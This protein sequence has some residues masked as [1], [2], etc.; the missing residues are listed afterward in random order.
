MAEPSPLVLEG[1]VK[2]FVD[3]GAVDGV[4]LEL[5]PGELLALVGPSGCG[6]STL[7]RLVAGLISPDAGRVTLGGQVVSDAHQQLPPE[8]RNVGLVFQEHALFPHLTVEQNVSFGLRDLGRSEAKSRVRES[9]ALVD[10]TDF[11]RRYPHELSGGERQRVALARALAPRPT[12]L[13][14]DEPFAS[15]DPNL[16][17]QLRAAVV[18]ALR[19]TGTPAVFVTHDQTEALAVGDRIA[20][21]RRGQIRQ[22]GTPERVFHQPVE[23]F[24]AAFMGEASFLAVA[25]GTLATALGPIEPSASVDSGQDGGVAMVRPDDLEFW[26][27]TDGAEP[28]AGAG[29]DEIIAT[30][31]RGDRWC[32]TIRLG[33][34]GSDRPNTEATV[35]AYGS[36][37]EPLAV[38]QRGLTELRPGHRQTLLRPEPAEVEP[39]TA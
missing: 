34:R 23:R 11:A 25:P 27:A 35:Q 26:P 4:S 33:G 32:Y 31:Y 7:L 5:A 14:L 2:R 8:R 10:M 12:L 38:G 20:V 21:M 39:P 19:S 37:L 22:I 1:V 15:L 16:R 36:H 6:K 13:L 3:V 18:E 29:A 17:V 30:E 9:L 28:P 24:V